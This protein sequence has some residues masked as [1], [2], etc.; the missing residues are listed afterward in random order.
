MEWLLPPA[1]AA[2]RLVAVE[3][4]V[5]ALAMSAGALGGVLGLHTLPL[6]ETYLPV[7]APAVPPPTA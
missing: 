5:E 4:L 1:R 7:L 6:A 3:D 2:V